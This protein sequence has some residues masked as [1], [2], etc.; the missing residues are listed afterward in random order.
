MI[1]MTNKKSKTKSK[2]KN[3]KAKPKPKGKRQ[4]TLTNAMVTAWGFKCENM[5]EAAVL[6]KGSL[7]GRLK[8]SGALRKAWDRGRFLRNIAQFASAGATKAEVSIQLGVE[9]GAFEVL[10]ADPE[11]SDVWISAQN[12]AMLAIKMGI[13]DH[14]IAGNRTAIKSLER[15]FGREKPHGAHLDIFKVTMA[16]LASIAQVSRETVHQWITTKELPRA[17]D[18]TF[19][20]RVVWEWFGLFSQRKVNVTPQASTVDEM[21]DIKT[22]AL[23]RAFDL[24][25]GKQ[26]DRDAVVAGYVGRLQQFL[27]LWDRLIDGV[28]DKC[29]NMP[30]QG[31][32]E[33]LAKFKDELRGE[34]VKVDIEMQLTES[35]HKEL[36]DFLKKLE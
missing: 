13:K 27:A 23:K 36:E 32:A 33:I 1:E 18:N 19:D 25:R 4:P 6:Y 14:A 9:L 16:Q 26:I 21:K 11:A 2:T 10:L 34:F 31:V 22:Q 29:S 15:I 30:K 35:Q 5:T 8:R 7:V 20:L 24:E 28:C 17:G 12:S 3:P